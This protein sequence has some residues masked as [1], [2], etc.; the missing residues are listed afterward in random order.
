[1]QR[2][3][4]FSQIT[5]RPIK[6]VFAGLCPPE[7]VAIK[8]MAAPRTQFDVSVI[9][10]FLNDPSLHKCPQFS[11]IFFERL[12]AV[13]PQ[14]GYCLAPSECC[15]SHIMLKTKQLADK[16]SL[17]IAIKSSCP[18]AESDNE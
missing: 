4:S 13:I 8:A 17:K 14:M 6:E 2:S 9:I 16:N 5:R 15:K 18:P 7:G 10:L 12:K 1:V 3:Q 11:S